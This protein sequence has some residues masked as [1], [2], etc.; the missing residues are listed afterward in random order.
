[1]LTLLLIANPQI[2]TYPNVLT[3][4]SHNTLSNRVQW[5][6]GKVSCSLSEAVSFYMWLWITRFPQQHCDSKNKSILT[7][8]APYCHLTMFGC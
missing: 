2:H 6:F 3:C 7:P 4:F 1:M 5:Y 8:N